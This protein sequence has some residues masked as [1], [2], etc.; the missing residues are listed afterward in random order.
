MNAK[1]NKW[2]RS[3]QLL[4]KKSKNSKS[5]WQQYSADK[6]TV[7]YDFRTMTF[8]ELLKKYPNFSD[9]FWRD[10]GESLKSQ[11]YKKRVLC[12]LTISS[13]HNLMCLLLH[14]PKS[15]DWKWSSDKGVLF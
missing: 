13:H 2:K 14:P 11:F 12:Q 4:E 10:K 15:D 9:F 7:I 5:K 1:A 8:P 6:R 3:I